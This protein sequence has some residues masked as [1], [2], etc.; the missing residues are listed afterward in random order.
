MKRYLLDTS[1]LILWLT[2]SSMQP[3]AMTVIEAG[4]NDVRVS[5]VS[6][7]EIGIKVKCGRL[8]LDVPVAPVVRDQFASID[9]TDA[10]VERAGAL[11]LH[12]R[13]P[14]DRLLLA[15]AM[16]LGLTLITRDQ[17]FGRYEVDV[18]RC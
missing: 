7:W 17:Q 2:G 6:L 5:P 15:Q 8:G 10:Q 1:A 9:I 4:A 13:D 14:F 18:L 3:D 12:H 16:D 11:P